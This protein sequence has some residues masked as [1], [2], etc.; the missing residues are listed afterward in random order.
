MKKLFLILLLFL[1]GCANQDE[2]T[3]TRNNQEM[4]LTIKHY[5]EGRCSVVVIKNAEQARNYKERLKKLLKEIED[6]EKEL[7]IKEKTN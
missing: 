3:Y 4:T 2:V 5:N 6:F 7:S 1:V